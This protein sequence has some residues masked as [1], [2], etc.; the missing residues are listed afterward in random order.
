VYSRPGR[1]AINYPPAGAISRE[2]W[3]FAGLPRGID[4]AEPLSSRIC[5][6]LFVLSGRQKRLRHCRCDRACAGGDQIAIP[7]PSD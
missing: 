3:C 1:E 7:N 2:N 6:S 4:A 5:K